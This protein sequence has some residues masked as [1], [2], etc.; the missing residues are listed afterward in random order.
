VLLNIG[1]MGT[2][3][4][5]P[6][7]AAILEGIGTWMK[8]NGESI[9][10]TTATP[11]PVQAWG[12]STRKGNT[13]YLHV[14]QWPAGGRVVVGGLK[15]RV[16]KASLLADPRRT[17]LKVESLGELDVLVRGPERA[18]DAAIPSSPW[19]WTASRAPIRPGCCR[20]TCSWTLCGRLTGAWPGN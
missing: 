9:H 3:A 5:D 11:L 4:F 20:P 8:A 2:G 17:P 18:P 14:L 13:L 16:V 1:P 19:S 10:G 12:E 15:S 7:D 6:K